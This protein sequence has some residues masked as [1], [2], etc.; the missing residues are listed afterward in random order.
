[1]P[2]KWHDGLIVDIEEESPSVKKFFLRIDDTLP[3]TPGQ[4]ITVDLPIA[5]K[6]R[7]RWRSYSV[8][9][10]L[11]E[12]Q[13]IELCIGKLENG[14]ATSYLFKHAQEGTAITFKGPLGGF[15]IPKNLDREIVMVCTGTGVAPFRSMIKYIQLHQLDFNKIHL[16]YGCR[17]EKDILYRDEFVRLQRQSPK[18][19]YDICLSRE[20][21]EGCYEGY[22]HQV[23]LEKY[24]E[25][26][27]DRL[28]MLC[29]W[30]DM[31]DDA[32]TNLTE[33]LQVKPNMIVQ[34]LY[35]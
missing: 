1:M 4:F 31:I 26:Q 18:F 24:G 9:N 5:E 6:R 34:E 23:Y 30:S 7:E 35:G 14:R 20:Q 17:Y 11:D 16:I 10:V 28:F 19:E 32:M 8:A 21:V 29:G 33:D 15:T 25:H 13:L 27:E 12:R 22:V 3:F 2:T